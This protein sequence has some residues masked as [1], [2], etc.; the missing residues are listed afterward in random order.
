MRLKKSKLESESQLRKLN[1]NGAAQKTLSSVIGD[2]KLFSAE[3]LG[4]VIICLGFWSQPNSMVNINKFYGRNQRIADKS[5]VPEGN[6]GDHGLVLD[7]AT[8]ERYR[9][10]GR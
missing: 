1:G 4:I 6:V 10:L 8:A 5:G 9:L 2:R 7:N 3:R